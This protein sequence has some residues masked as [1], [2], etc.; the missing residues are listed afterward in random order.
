M[1]HARSPTPRPRSP[2]AGSPWPRRS[3]LLAMGAGASAALAPA[4]W[5]R[6]APGDML[7]S[8]TASDTSTTAAAP[9]DGSLG[10]LA[11]PAML[12]GA[13]SNPGNLAGNDG[14]IIER[15]MTLLSTAQHWASTWTGPG[16]FDAEGIAEHDAMVDW[17][18]ERG[19]AVHAW[20]CFGPQHYLPSWLVDGAP[21]MSTGELVGHMED[22]I[23]AIAGSGDNSTQVG[24]W[25]VVNEAARKEGGYEGT[26]W[27]A[28]GEEADRSGLTG[29]Q[30][31]MTEHRAYI[32]KA[33]DLANAAS[34]SGKLGLRD[35]NM[36]FLGSPKA[37]TVYQL[38]TH[39]LKTGRRLEVIE[40]QMHMN[41]YP[42]GSVPAGYQVVQNQNGS[43]NWDSFKA[44]VERYQ[45]L[46]LQ[47][48]LGEVDF[49]TEG[50]EPGSEPA[51]AAQQVAAYGLMKAAREAGVEITTMWGLREDSMDEQSNK[52]MAQILE[53]AGTPKPAYEGLRRALEET[54]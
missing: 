20:F 45:E 53:A 7:A 41:A 1:Q 8:G 35:N 16:Q 38:A 47:V 11:A 50:Y 2:Q 22:A 9:V 13:H 49:Y 43:Y 27:N 40:F 37:S 19:L 46:G 23:R 5:G 44:N 36:E 3:L 33:F 54:R 39:L 24:Y 48:H 42:A 51:R 10:A 31:P 4:A 18:V 52:A 15:E 21:G 17:A 32:G 28:L 34:L 26:L 29:A 14:P 6:Q 30:A 12:V 25:T